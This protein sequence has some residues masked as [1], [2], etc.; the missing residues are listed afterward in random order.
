MRQLTVAVPILGVILL[1]LASGHLWLENDRLTTLA[2][3]QREAPEASS[4]PDTREPTFQTIE[5]SPGSQ[6]AAG[7]DVA[8]LHAQYQA[9]TRPVERDR[10]LRRMADLNNIEPLAFL[11]ELIEGPEARMRTAA[12]EAMGS[13]GGVTARGILE[14]QLHTTDWGRVSAGAAGLAA[15]ADD[16]AAKTL[17]R[18][19]LEPGKARFASTFASALGTL[20][21]PD[22]IGILTQRLFEGSPQVARESARGLANSRTGM[23]VLMDSLG[24]DTAVGVRRAA[25]TALAERPEDEIDGVLG[26]I[27]GDRGSRLRVQAIDALG[28]RRTP[29]A[30]RLL[31]GVLA[32]GPL[33]ERNAAVRALA[34]LDTDAAADVLVGLLPR[35]A[36]SQRFS[37]IYA[38]GRMS[39]P[40]ALDAIRAM[41]N[42]P[43]PDIHRTAASAISYNHPEILAELNPLE[44]AKEIRRYV[45]R[46][47]INVKGDEAIPL[48]EQAVRSG[49]ASLAEAA[50]YSLEGPTSDRIQTLLVEAIHSEDPRI[51]RAG[52]QSIGG[53]Q[54]VPEPARTA[55]IQRIA[56]ADVTPQLIYAMGE[57]GQSS[58]VRD[59]LIS[60][61]KNGDSQLR[62]AAVSALGR[63]GFAGTS[64]L[65]GQM[66]KD[67]E[68]DD[69]TRASAMT[70]LARAGDLKSRTVLIEMARAGD[71]PAIN[72][73]REV[74]TDDS[75]AALVQLAGSVDKKQANAAFQA[76]T[77]SQRPSA[78]QALV[79]AVKSGDERAVQAVYSLGNRESPEAREALIDAAWEGKAPLRSAAISAMRYDMPDADVIPVLKRA[80]VDSEPQVVNSALSV[81]E[82]RPG[83]SAGDLLVEM[84]DAE[85]DNT[86]RRAASA[87]KR[88][89]GAHARANKA[90]I[91][92]LLAAEVAMD[93]HVEIFL[94]EPDIE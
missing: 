5:C 58:D 87:I 38:I 4:E 59:A 75:V 52:L 94:E 56:A 17:I 35:V 41:L 83:V 80:L 25:L 76:L 78:T 90:L 39:Q 51:A 28:R 77:G 45:F 7:P 11:Q 82:Y 26:R 61:L 66:V 18:M 30:L 9:A 43:S 20:A 92:E 62:S 34:S 85:D 84:L 67:G 44:V 27:L 64:A 50:L 73:L 10:I 79:E 8:E 57:M 72:A 14:V 71:L 93:D 6:A 42:D 48:L 74:D 46:A 86:R 65:L 22:A 60:A 81:L 47:L 54:A 63:A 13:I 2:Q 33:S 3:T 12:A 89:G 49:N 19:L 32:N 53:L 15:M 37:V 24:E 23:K 88:R 91:N 29:Q 68:L 55:L 69:A 36:K 1:S 70:A 31:T 21:T 40:V 16:N